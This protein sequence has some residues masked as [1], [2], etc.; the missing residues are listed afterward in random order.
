MDAKITRIETFAR[1]QLA[2][3]RITTED[4]SE[5][6][7]Q[8][9][10]YNADIA[11][12][13]L[14]RQVAPHVIGK[15]ANNIDAIVDRCFEANHKFPWS[16]VAR[17][18]TGIDTALWDWRG[19]R[20]GKSVCELLGG[21]PTAI[22]IYG[23]SINWTIK[24]ADEAGRLVKLRDEMGIGAFKIRIGSMCGHNQDTWPGRTE[25]LVPTVRKAL[26]DKVKLLVDANSCYT[27]DKA[28]EVGRMLEDNGV[29]H[30]EEPCP[31][32]ELEWTAQVAA[33][34]EIP[35]AGGEQDVDL[36]QWRRMIAMRAIDIA[37]PDLCY[38]GGMSRGLRV[39]RMARDAGLPCVPHSANLSLVTVFT[40]HLLGAIP[41]GIYLEY[42]IEDM[43]WTK[44]LFEPELAVKEGKIRIPD[45]PGW[46][47]NVSATWMEQS[48][49]QISR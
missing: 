46:G 16:Y 41:N 40:L 48:Q 35:I 3:V 24:P 22:P 18:V 14:H 28:I 25:E 37:Q 9:S 4:G 5:G 21:K 38:I 11:A 45:E 26:G 1:Q 47:V 33:A 27:P 39:A 8:L 23:A 20:E 19:K 49:Y 15:D 13:V 30:Y 44:G 12:T 43:D 36:A 17:A 29:C 32:W 10:P 7:G 31:Y 6:I 42:C 34:L 2:I